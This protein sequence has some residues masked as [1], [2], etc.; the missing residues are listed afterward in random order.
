[1]NDFLLL[2]EQLSFLMPIILMG[3]LTK[4]ISAHWI[5]KQQG[6]FNLIG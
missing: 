1:M 3:A 2:W 5:E 6:N 4:S